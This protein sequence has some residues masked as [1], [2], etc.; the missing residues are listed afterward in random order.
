MVT[1]QQQEAQWAF[2]MDENKLKEGALSVAYPKGLPVLLIRKEG[3]VYALS[4]KCAHMACALSAGSL[5]GFMLKCP[6]H[7]WLYDIRTGEF[8]NAPEIKL[9]V[10]ECKADAGKIFVKVGGE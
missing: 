2:A 4:N 1:S 8:F 5:F 7:D 6:C 10:Y 3:R 9:T